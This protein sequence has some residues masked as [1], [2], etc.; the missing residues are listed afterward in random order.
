MH[1][2]SEMAQTVRCNGSHIEFDEGETI[3]TE[4][5]YKYTLAGFTKLAAGAGLSLEQ[6]WLDDEELF[7]VH[8]LSAA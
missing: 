5:S 1:L 7:S 2:V 6:S 8:Y 3:H 4:S